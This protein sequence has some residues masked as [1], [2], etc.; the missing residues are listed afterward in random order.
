MVFS[1]K[2][3]SGTFYGSVRPDLDFPVL[4]DHYMN[5][6][7]N[8]DGLISRTYKL[9]EINEEIDV[10]RA[11][12]GMYPPDVQEAMD[13]LGTPCCRASKGQQRPIERCRAS[14]D[15]AKRH[16]LCCPASDPSESPVRGTPC[17]R[18]SE[19][20]QRPI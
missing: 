15:C 17:C 6:R 8:I 3:M 2:T 10:A 5:K 20:Q 1:E 7:L 12:E 14:R 13:N 16:P 19:G 9:D 11:F 18:A 4:V